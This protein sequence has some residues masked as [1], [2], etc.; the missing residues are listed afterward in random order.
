MVVDDSL[1]WVGELASWRWVRW[2]RLSLRSQQRQARSL[3][4]LER[5]LNK[6][7]SWISA[8]VALSVST[9]C[10]S[11]RYNKASLPHLARARTSNI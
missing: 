4:L 7:P 3:E 6:R 10:F 5:R 11:L 2:V 8:V 1:V 9:K